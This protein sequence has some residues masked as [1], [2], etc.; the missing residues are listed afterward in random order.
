MIMFGGTIFLEGTPMLYRLFA[1]RSTKANDSREFNQITNKYGDD[2]IEEL[3]KRAKDPSLS[4][5]DRKHWRRLLRFAKSS[6]DTLP[7]NNDCSN[8]ND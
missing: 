2:S 7:G 4:Q 3:R 8:S 5:R 6:P 1:S